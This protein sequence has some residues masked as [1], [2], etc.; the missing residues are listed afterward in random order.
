MV[1]TAFLVA[2]AFAPRE[3]AV[4]VASCEEETVGAHV[5]ALREEAGA[6]IVPSWV[7]PDVPE[8]VWRL[9]DAAAAAEDEAWRRCL[10]EVAERHAREARSRDPVDPGSQF[11]HVMVLG[12]RANT[13]GGRTRIL[14]A[15]ELYRELV[16]FLEVAPDH[17]HARHMLGRLHAGILRMDRVTRWLAVNLLGGGALREATWEEAERNLEFAE[18]A[19]PQVL[20]HHLQLANLYRDTDRPELALRELAHIRDLEGTTVL[21]RSVAAEARALEESLSRW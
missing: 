18:R 14:A 12:M 21:E 16:A 17:A 15:R 7:A 13:E 10:L 8:S 19:A 4:L 2:L 3:A 9:V 11:A 6:D 20:D 1:A 5:G